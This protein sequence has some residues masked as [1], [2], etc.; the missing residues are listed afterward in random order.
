MVSTQ[1]GG[2]CRRIREEANGEVTHSMIAGVVVSLEQI[3]T[4]LEPGDSQALPL[5]SWVTLDRLLR[6]SKL[7]FLSQGTTSAS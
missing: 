6:L 3:H 4:A 7:L 5:R 2:S 1:S